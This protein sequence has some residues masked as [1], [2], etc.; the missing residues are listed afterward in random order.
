MRSSRIK[1]LVLPVIRNEPFQCTVKNGNHKTHT[2]NFSQQ[3]YG[4][5]TE[6]KK[7][8]S[9]ISNYFVI[10]QKFCSGKMKLQPP[11]TAAMP[12]YGQ[13]GKAIHSYST[14]TGHIVNQIKHL[15]T[16]NP[17]N[18][19]LHCDKSSL[20]RNKPIPNVS[21]QQR[22]TFLRPHFE[23]HQLGSVSLLEIK[24]FLRQKSIDYEESKACICLW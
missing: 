18:N 8:D 24:K 9:L 5:R 21:Y 7:T 23:Y 6:I 17:T 3:K 20:L 22:R 4:A 16:S 14:K 19:T 2:F 10:S 13:T 12:S 11:L 1:G 15:H